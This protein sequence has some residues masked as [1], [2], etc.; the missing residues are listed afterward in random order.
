MKKILLLILISMLS[1]QLFAVGNNN[2]K[3]HANNNK[4]VNKKVIKNDKKKDKKQVDME[5]YIKR[6]FELM[7][8]SQKADNYSIQDNL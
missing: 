6:F 4:N 2:N 3:K 5:H 7:A 8:E 1:V